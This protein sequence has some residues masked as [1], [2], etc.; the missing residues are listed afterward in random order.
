M[1]MILCTITVC[2]CLHGEK[3]SGFGSMPTRSLSK[4]LQ[5]LRKEIE[6][7]QEAQS[8]WGDSGGKTKLEPLA[9]NRSNRNDS[10]NFM[11]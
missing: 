11:R 2:D 1:T 9:M 3:S 5:N 10:Q 8:F 7:P 4:W 6:L